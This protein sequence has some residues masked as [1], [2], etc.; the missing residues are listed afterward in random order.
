[1][2]EL[3]KTDNIVDGFRKAKRPAHMPQEVWDN[4]WKEIR[5]PTQHLGLRKEAEVNGIPSIIWD[6]WEHA[7]A[8]DEKLSKFC[9]AYEAGKEYGD[10]HKDAIDWTRKQ[11][12]KFKGIVERFANDEAT[13][14]DL[15]E[16]VKNGA[17]EYA[18]LPDL[19]EIEE[20]V[21]SILDERDHLSDISPHLQA[22]YSLTQNLNFSGV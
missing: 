11:L 13:A 16:I 15:E 4:M 18:D 7:D 3:E 20:I 2:E 17:T 10:G 14:S 8:D 19:S 22:K 9:D 1:M 21:N 6:S 5:K 12:K